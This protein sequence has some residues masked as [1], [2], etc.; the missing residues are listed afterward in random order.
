M[1]KTFQIL[2]ILLGV[3][4]LVEGGYAATINIGAVASATGTGY[5]LKEDGSFNLTGKIRVGTFSKTQAELQSIIDSWGA[6]DPFSKYDPTFSKWT[7]LNNYFTEV[8]I[9]GTSGTS[10]AGWSFSATGTISGT[11]N[12][13]DTTIVPVGSQLY[14]WA[15][16]I[17]SFTSSDFITAGANRTQ[18]ALVTDSVDWIAPS[19]GTKSLNLALID[20]AG[21]LIGTDLSSLSSNSVTMIPEPSTGILVTVGL[22]AIAFARKRKM[23]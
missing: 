14:V 3:G 17:S 8:G 13:V 23:S 4:A 12:S 22:A 9:G 2:A 21:V 7:S 18:W 20:S 16:T 19:T 5:Y 10:V 11:S 1:K 15:T 6:N